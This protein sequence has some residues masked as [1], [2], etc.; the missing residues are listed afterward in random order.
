MKNSIKWW[1]NKMNKKSLNNIID[2]M[3]NVVEK[4]KDEIFHISEQS[5]NE[6][7]SLQKELATTK[8]LVKEY[9]KRNDELEKEVRLYRRRLSQVSRDF[10]KYTED[11][12]R[13]VY[14]KTHE[15]QTKLAIMR[16]EEESLRQKR[17][18]LERRLIQLGKTIEHA[19]NLGRKVSVILTYLH[20]DFPQVNKALKSAKEKQQLGLKIIEAQE[21]ERKRIS[22]EIHDGPAQSLANI[23]IRS[24]IVDLSFREGNIEQAIEE[25]NAI[26]ENIRASLQEVRRIIYDLRPM[27]LDDLGLFPTIKKHIST[28][29]Q[30]NDIEIELLVLGD[31]K[32]LPPNYEVAIFRLIQEALQNAIKHA[33]ATMIK[34]S[35]EV[36]QN[37][38]N[39]LIWDNGVGFD[40]N[41]KDESSF[42]IMGMKERVDILNGD[43][44]LDSTIGQ[45][46]IVRITI[47][48]HS[49]E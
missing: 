37:K 45:G 10:A 12:I 21:M 31:E 19:N 8:I 5:I 6:H 24:E 40:V 29:S 27:A 22:R 25:M 4:S 49:T 28:V 34:V 20:D 46:T 3:T 1:L 42:G 35:I 47:P 15:L 16:R 11:E 23:L 2:E 33:N 41:E 44:F 30:H 9:I 17:D 13:D 48:Y 18:D 7:S 36:L 26:R 39:V 14:E 38:I 43:F 32:R